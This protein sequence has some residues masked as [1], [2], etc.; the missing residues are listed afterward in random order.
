LVSF[1]LICYYFGFVVY[2]EESGFHDDEDFEDGILEENDVETLDGAEEEKKSNSQVEEP[3][4]V[5]NEIEFRVEQEEE[6]EERKDEK[7][8]MEDLCS[9]F[10]G[11]HI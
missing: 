1:K 10:K 4:I 7:K 5:V 8:E 3:V 11:Q 6:E 9:Q 2:L